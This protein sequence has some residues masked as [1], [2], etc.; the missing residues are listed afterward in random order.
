MGSPYTPSVEELRHRVDQ[1][2][3]GSLQGKIAV[4]RLIHDLITA[5]EEMNEDGW[6]M[7]EDYEP[8][9]EADGAET[10]AAEPEAA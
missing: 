5:L 3:V 2:K 7:G 9:D 6:F 1:Y 4:D 10:G 8:D